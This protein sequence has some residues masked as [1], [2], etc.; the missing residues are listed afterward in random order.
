MRQ[1][2][3]LR[4]LFL[5]NVMS[6]MMAEIILALRRTIPT[7]NSDSVVMSK[8]ET[9]SSSFFLSRCWQCFFHQGARHTSPNPLNL[10]SEVYTH[11]NILVLKD[12]IFYHL[13]LVLCAQV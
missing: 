10:A 2:V 7:V 9:T 3:C 4:V 12:Q 1:C 5:I 6:Q 11:W 13:V 8:R